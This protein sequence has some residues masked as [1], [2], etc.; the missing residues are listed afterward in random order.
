M[1]APKSPK[2]PKLNLISL[3]L[4]ELLDEED[5]HPYEMQQRLR[6][7]GRD[8]LVKLTAGSL[9]HSVERLEKLGLITA[10]ET[11]RQG[12]LPERTVYA[13]TADGRAAFTDRLREMVATPDREYPAFPLALAFLHSL[14]RD[15][16]IERLTWRSTMLEAEIAAEEAVAGRLTEQGT[17]PLYFLDL[18]WQIAAHRSQLEWIQKTIQQLSTNSLTWPAPASARRAAAPGEDGDDR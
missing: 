2:S 15:E 8:R 7:R 3:A 10:V 12:R 9:Y 16:A 6:D 4:L 14:E 17:E 13:I 18:T 1:A 5:M 11:N